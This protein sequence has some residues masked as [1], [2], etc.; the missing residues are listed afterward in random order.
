MHINDDDDNDDDKDNDDRQA[1]QVCI[2]YQISKS[3][4]GPPAKRS[5]RLSAKHRK[6]NREKQVVRARN[7]NHQL[8]TV[9]SAATRH[10][11][12]LDYGRMCNYSLTSTEH[13]TQVFMHRLY[14]HVHSVYIDTVEWEQTEMAQQIS[15]DNPNPANH[16]SIESY[17]TKKNPNP[18]V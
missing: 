2:G 1:M 9:L 11:C 10:T 14:S 7:C 16:M 18:Y 4:T 3:L 8:A 12:L 5:C 15:Y 17:K 6:S 13:N